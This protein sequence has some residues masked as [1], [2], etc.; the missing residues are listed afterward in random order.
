VTGSQAPSLL[1]CMSP[2]LCRFSAAGMT[3]Y[4]RAE[5]AGG[6]K[7][8]RHEI[9]GN[10]AVTVPRALWGFSHEAWRV[11]CGVKRL[12][13]LVCGEAWSYALV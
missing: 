3:V 8:P 6:R 1:H 2:L 9:A 7:A 4:R 13:R 12:P 10:V 5:A 11:K